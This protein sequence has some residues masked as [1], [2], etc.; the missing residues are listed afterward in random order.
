MYLKM[1]REELA[2]LF[3]TKDCIE[4]MMAFAQSENQNSKG[5]DRGA[6]KNLCL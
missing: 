2:K 1:E 3:T 5:I 6:I 4:G